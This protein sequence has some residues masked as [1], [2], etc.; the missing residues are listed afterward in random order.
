[1]STP[2]EIAER[3][4]RAWCYAAGRELTPDM[5]LSGEEVLRASC[6]ADLVRY[7]AEQGG[8]DAWSDKGGSPEE[9][10][11]QRWHRAFDELDGDLEAVLTRLTTWEPATPE[12]VR[13]LERMLS[14]ME[15]EAS[16][17]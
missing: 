4:F 1:M 12:A 3:V 6:F 16:L 13:C 15:E 2:K 10:F 7:V 9:W 14:E 5:R 8:W 11:E 17:L